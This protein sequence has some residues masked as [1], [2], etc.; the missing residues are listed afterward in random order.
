[1]MT[2]TDVAAR[3][4]ELR[5]RKWEFLPGLIAMSLIAIMGFSIVMLF[6]FPM[7]MTAEAGT[8]AVALV[9]AVATNVG[10]I[11]GFFFGS[12]KTAREKDV[13]NAAQAQTIATLATDGPK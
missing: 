7:P 6:M 1:M 4:E 9:T 12:S 5:S 11:V 3:T 10:M 2:M 13:T 8:L